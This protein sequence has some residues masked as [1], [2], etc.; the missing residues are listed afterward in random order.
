MNRYETNTLE[1]HRNNTMRMRAE[2]NPC[3]KSDGARAKEFKKFIVAGC[4]R[5]D[6]QGFE[7][8]TKHEF[9]DHVDIK[10]NKDGF[11]TG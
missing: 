8:S 6:F 3:K 5:M 2:K 4:Q 9:I 7:A 1:Y 10:F 11:R